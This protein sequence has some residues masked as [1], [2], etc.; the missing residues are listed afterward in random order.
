MKTAMQRFIEYL[1]DI[2]ERDNIPNYVITT[3][4]NCLQTEKEQIINS[5]LEY[6]MLKG[7]TYAESQK[8]AEDY[9]NSKFKN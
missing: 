4:K 1:Q 7:L 9:Y 2:Q 6:G 3:A 5:R 8:L